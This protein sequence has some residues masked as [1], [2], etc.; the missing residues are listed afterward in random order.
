MT[1][2]IIKFKTPQIMERTKSRLDESTAKFSVD[3]TLENT[4]QIPIRFVDGSTMNGWIKLNLSN[5]DIIILDMW[6]VE[7]FYI[8]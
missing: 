6:D 2:I 7:Y 4:L 5:H 8:G 1:Q 3:N